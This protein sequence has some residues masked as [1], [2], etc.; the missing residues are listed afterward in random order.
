MRLVEVAEI[1]NSSGTVRIAAHVIAKIVRDVF[2]LSVPGV[3]RMDSDLSDTISQAIGM[4]CTNRVHVSVNEAGASINLY[5]LVKHGVRIPDLA[6]TVQHKVKE[7][8]HKET[9]VPV[10]TVNIYVQGIIFDNEKA[11][12]NVGR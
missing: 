10:E 6:L 2:T 3:I 9:N 5:I 12:D 11:G 4:E 1:T 8:V 7:E